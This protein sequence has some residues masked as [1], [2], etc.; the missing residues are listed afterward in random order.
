MKNATKAKT[1]QKPQRVNNR[2]TAVHEKHNKG[3]DIMGTTI[4]K[5]FYMKNI[6]K[7]K[8]LWELQ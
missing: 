6:T 2:K 8:T 1:L 3:Q 5:Q 7:A 4:G